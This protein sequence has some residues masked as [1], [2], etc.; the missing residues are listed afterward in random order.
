MTNRRCWL[1][2]F[3]IF[4]TLSFNGFAQNDPHLP[5]VIKE[6]AAKMGQ[7]FVKADYKTFVHYSYPK[8][9]EMMGGAAK[10]ESILTKAT[11]DMKTNSMAITRLS[12][13]EPS[14]IVRSGGEWQCMLPEHTEIKLKEGRI[15]TISTLLAFSSDKGLHW[16]FL[17]TS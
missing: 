5:A 14:K 8:L 2:C 11:E 1:S 13:D 17:D 15:V 7:A 6:Q 9:I 4:I 3:V 10:M 16:T 12:F